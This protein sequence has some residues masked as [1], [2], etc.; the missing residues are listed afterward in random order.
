MTATICFVCL[1]LL[2]CLGCAEEQ[3]FE[4]KSW[5]KRLNQ[6]QPPLEI[7]DAIGLKP[8]MV[9]G[10]VGA[11]TGRMTIWLADRV[12]SEGHV[13]ANDINQDSL[14]QLASRCEK[15]GIRNV[16]II[17]GELEDPRL[18]AGALD[19]VFMINVYHHADNPVALVR[20][21]IPSLKPD[22]VL[23]IVEC[24]PDKVDWG[25]EEGCTRKQD[26]IQQLDQAGFEDVRIEGQGF[27]KEDNIFLSRPK[28]KPRSSP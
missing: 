3:K 12:G 18:P 21:A 4:L 16:E 20:N 5:E 14:D 9:V 17:L 2:P 13:V 22:G 11:G 24:D 23:A 28:Q 6:R 8:G 15:E 25:A 26:M 10:E 19:M 7:I 27:L 1:L